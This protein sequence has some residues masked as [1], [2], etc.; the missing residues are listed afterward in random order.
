[1][2][3]RPF[4][5]GDAAGV[6]NLIVG[7]QRGEFEISITADDQ[8]DLSSIPQFYQAGAG[9]FWVAVVDGEV[10]GTLGLRDLGDGDVALR[11]M[12]VA[13]KYRGEPHRVAQRLLSA[14]LAWAAEK[15]SRNIFLGTTSRFWRPTASMKRTALSSCRERRCRKHFPSWRSTRVFIGGRCSAGS[16]NADP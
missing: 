5:N 13:S 6:T 3:I 12:F 15:N 10:I 2:N 9:N 16:V 1:M 11:K 4:E 14:A 8:P 7:I